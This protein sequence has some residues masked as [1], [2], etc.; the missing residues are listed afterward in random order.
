MS[1]E[2]IKKLKEIIAKN[3]E[4]ISELEY[5]TGNYDNGVLIKKGVP[6]ITTEYCEI[7]IIDSNMYF[8]YIILSNSA[9][10]KLIKLLSNYTNVQIYG[11][12]FFNNNF[13][14]K[15]NFVWEDF[16]EKLKK[17]KYTQIQFNY[18]A[19]KLNPQKVYL[20]YIKINN[21][22]SSSGLQTINQLKTKLNK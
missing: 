17:E 14:P 11:F 19:I 2:Y 21:L 13:F 5:T 6:T 22:L 18:S 7:G 16:K 3:N 10:K 8:V 12:K 1:E 15:N 4:K 9:T 20:E